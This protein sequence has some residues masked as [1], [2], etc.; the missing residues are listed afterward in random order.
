MMK[1]LKKKIKYDKMRGEGDEPECVAITDDATFMRWKR[2]T[3]YTL[4]YGSG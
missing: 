2:E 1:S 4:R 3:H